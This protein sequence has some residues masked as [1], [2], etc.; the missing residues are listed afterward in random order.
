MVLIHEGVAGFGKLLSIS[1]EHF[2][3]GGLVLRILWELEL[4]V[5]ARQEV[6]LLQGDNLHQNAGYVFSGFRKVENKVVRLHGVRKLLDLGKFFLPGFF[7]FEE[8]DRGA[9]QQLEEG[10]TVSVLNEAALKR[11]PHDSQNFHVDYVHMVGPDAG[12]VGKEILQQVLAPLV[13]LELS[14]VLACQVRVLRIPVSDLLP[15]ERVI[16]F[17]LQR[18]DLGSAAHVVFEVVVQEK[19]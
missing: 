16:H 5:S 13:D 8:T 17:N 6:I 15:L 2:L 7:E 14:D 11:E 18:V 19:L 1:I 10:V 3:L 4:L 12:N 9:V